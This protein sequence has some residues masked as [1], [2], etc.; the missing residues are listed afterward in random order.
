[1]SDSDT[2]YIGVRSCG[3]VTFV[4]VQ[5]TAA[6]STEAIELSRVIRSGRRI[7]TVTVG[8][9]KQRLVADCPHKENRL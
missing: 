9:A 6:P 1:M 8:E 7:E 2:A 5:G 4:M 3:C